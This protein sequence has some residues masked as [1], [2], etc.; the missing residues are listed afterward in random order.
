VEDRGWWWVLVLVEI[1]EGL[2]LGLGL[3]V[4]GLVFLNSQKLCTCSYALLCLSCSLRRSTVSE[5]IWLS[6]FMWLS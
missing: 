4:Q 6:S 3:G 2:E 1:L 5:R